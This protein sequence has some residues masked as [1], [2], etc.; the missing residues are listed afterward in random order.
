MKKIFLIVFMLLLAPAA[1]AATYYVS[2]TGLDDNPGSETKPFASIQKGLD[3]A[4]VPGDTVIVEDGIY[5]RVTMTAWSGTEGRPITLKARN[6][7]EVFIDASTT[8][9]GWTSIGM[10]K[11]RSAVSTNTNLA[12]WRVGDMLGLKRC[13]AE[14]AVD[15]EG[16]YYF[17]ANAKQFTIYTAAKPEARIYKQLMNP[18]SIYS[19]RHIVVDGI[20]FQYGNSGI[21]TTLDTAGPP[22]AQ[23]LVQHCTF[24]YGSGLG[25]LFIASSPARNTSYITVDHCMVRN[26][27]DVL[28]QN[29][30]GIKFAANVNEANGSDVTVSNCTIYNCRYHGI[31]FS[32][33]W[34][35]GTFLNNRIYNFSLMGNGA[36]SG[37]RTGTPSPGKGGCYIYGNDI[38]N[39]P[40]G[41]G[42]SLGSAIYVQENTNRVRIHHN[43]LHNNYWHGIYVFST[44]GNPCFDVQICNN[45]IY[46]NG[47]AGIRVEVSKSIEILNNTFYRNGTTSQAGS[48]ACLSINGMAAQGVV[49]R[50]NIVYNPSGPGYI[51][52]GIP[53]ALLVTSD[54]NV[55]FKVSNLPY[56]HWAGANRDFAWWTAT[57][58]QDL[59]SYNQDPLFKN[60]ATRDLS[61]LEG[62]PAQNHGLNF[63]QHFTD[64]FVH[65]ER[66]TA[67][68]IGA[69]EASEDSQPP[70]EPK[71]PRR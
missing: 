33:G 22:T 46:D 24:E 36:A 64:D 49:F 51:I 14:A 67:W 2:N 69:Y 37:I 50:N 17:D 59:H 27:D 38:G 52:A 58:K 31:Q 29:G 23:I 42:P 1:F 41:Q 20:T 57:E 16:E 10:N 56:I 55:L 30:H 40:N 32:N 39:G 7:G 43:R 12:L 19:V 26:S 68:D 45:L 62:S 13:T 28:H 48:G 8:V 6:R 70:G 3:A 25:V 71:G 15:A 34:S 9:S 35:E 65:R 11:Y 61:I 63:S 47:T 53:N 4:T 54:H 66:G 60:A 21:G 18:L 44:T 5:K